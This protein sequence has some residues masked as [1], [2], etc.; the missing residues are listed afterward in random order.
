MTGRIAWISIAPVKALGLVDLQEAELTENGIES[1]RRFHLI[2]AR[3]RLVNG[4]R[5]G[6]LVAVRPSY[7]VASEHLSLAFPD[8]TVAAGAAEALGE[9]LVTVFYGRPVRGHAVEGPFSEALSDVAGEPLRLVRPERPA[10]AV[11]RGRGGAMS[12]VS[13]A[14][15]SAIAQA[16]GRDEPLDGRRFRMLFGVEGVPAHAEDAWLDREVR[17]GDA[18]VV[19]TGNTG[20]CTITSQDPD[21]GVRD[22]DTLEAIR[23][24]RG[25]VETREPLP[26]GVHGRVARPGTVR[27][28]DP[29]G[30]V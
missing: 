18:V 10:A 12:M 23:S 3:G 13:T 27:V 14:A 26:F 2:D 30:L 24:Y 29:V 5:L 19:P 7:D 11:D 6:I 16:A 17:V 21:T 22:V 8:G 9:G 1:N 20:R 25:G 15:L 28:G 4:K